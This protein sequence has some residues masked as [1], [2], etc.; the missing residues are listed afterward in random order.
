VLHG[1]MSFRGIVNLTTLEEP[2]DKIR[3]LQK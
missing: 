3:M 1:L 2:A